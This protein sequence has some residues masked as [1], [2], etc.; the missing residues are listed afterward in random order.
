M[1]LQ[2]R[3]QQ[4]EAQVKTLQAMVGVRYI[5]I[6]VPKTGGNYLRAALHSAVAGQLVYDDN[7]FVSVDAEHD[8]LVDY[9]PNGSYLKHWF[10][11]GVGD[12]N[13]LAGKVCFTV[14]RNPYDWLVSYYHVVPHG[15]NVNSFGAFIATV[16][17]RNKEWP[18]KKL[19]YFPFFS[20]KGDFLVDYLFHQDNLDT[21]LEEFADVTNGL[22]YI[23]QDKVKVS[24]KRT[25]P[26]YKSYY[27]DELIAIVAKTWNRELRLYGYNYDGRTKGLL[28]KVIT[29]DIKGRLKYD[30]AT[31]RLL[32]DGEEIV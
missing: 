32:G 28:D 10:N 22:Y 30:W 14:V 5:F 20:Y 11:F 29:A 25:D 2:E 8:T 4:L 21:E 16:A 13:R 26:D 6:P 27:T 9:P 15:A 3:V 24:A 12:T 19:I 7:H 31:D 23:K 17:D 1:G 18:C